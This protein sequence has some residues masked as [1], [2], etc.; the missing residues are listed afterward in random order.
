VDYKRAKRIKTNY[1]EVYFEERKHRVFKKTVKYFYVR[2]KKGG[3]RIFELVGNSLEGMTPAKAN[4][5]RID[6]I[7]GSKLSNKE[8]RNQ[9]NA[10]K[11]AETNKMT[12][13]RLWNTYSTVNSSLSRMRTDRGIYKNHLEKPFGGKEPHEIEFL[14]VERL[15]RK[16][17]KTHK[18]ATV[19][20]I[21]ELLRRLSNFG[22]NNIKVGGQSVKG[23]SFKIKMPEVDNEKTEDLDPDEFQ[24]LLDAIEADIS[25]QA[26]N[27]MKMVLFTGMRRGELFRLRWDD[28]D[29]HKNFITIRDP[30]GKK[31]QK[32]PLS[33][34]AYNLLMTH[35]R[36]YTGSPFVFPGRNGN[37][38]T[39]IKLQINRIKKRAGL[40]K[41]FRPLHGLRHV[42]ASMLASSGKVDMYH[43]QKLLTHKSSSMTQRY[44]HL[45]DESLKK[46][47]EV[48]G[49]IVMSIGAKNNNVH[50][51]KVAEGA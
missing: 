22:A 47:A 13:S 32:I 40:P 9:E 36:P 6:R 3:K 39:D 7:S 50:N 48:S 25:T 37:Q 51:H 34:T 20:G 35:E 29:F 12:I 43:L 21:L 28:V 42:F 30:K 31:D 2:F 27:F 24:R 49:D 17:N 15:K 8:R 1:P 38:R 18:P 41:D 45:R 44:A 33:S 11:E 16:L 26:G 19:W 14:D 46:A 4:K 23:L 10:T 5:E